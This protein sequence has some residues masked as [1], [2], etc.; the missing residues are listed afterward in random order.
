MYSKYI[1]YNLLNIYNFIF[2]SYKKYNIVA[3]NMENN[4]PKK[5]LY[6]TY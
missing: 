5:T 3:K 6:K 2:S 4:L 1:L